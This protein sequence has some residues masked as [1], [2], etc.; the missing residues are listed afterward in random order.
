VKKYAMTGNRRFHG[1][2]TDA[3]MREQII[4]QMK[5]QFGDKIVI[6]SEEY[7]ESD[8]EIQRFCKMCFEV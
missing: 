5:E 2:L 8:K 3:E 6:V 4:R 1:N 7:V